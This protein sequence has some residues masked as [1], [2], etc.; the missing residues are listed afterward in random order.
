MSFYKSGLPRLNPKPAAEP[1][2]EEALPPVEA[3]AG[4]TPMPDE[5]DD[6]PI[7]SEPLKPM[8]R[9]QAV[10][11]Q[12]PKPIPR[13]PATPPVVRPRSPPAP[14]PAAKAPVVNRMKASDIPW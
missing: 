4:Y 2:D 8:P 10:F 14:K 9:P 11:I 3:D 12:P 6:R 5:D 7:L 1:V 13:V